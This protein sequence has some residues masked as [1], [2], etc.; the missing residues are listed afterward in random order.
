MRVVI[1]CC[2][3]LV[4]ET[5]HHCKVVMLVETYKSSCFMNVELINT[6]ELEPP[7]QEM[8][9]VSKLILCYGT[10]KIV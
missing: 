7:V 4:I 2:I 1:T 5:L 6:P 10:M 9:R 8:P 3:L